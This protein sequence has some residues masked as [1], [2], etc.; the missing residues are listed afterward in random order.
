MRRALILALVLA[1]SA[2][3]AGL[4]PRSEDPRLI[5]WKTQASALRGLE[6]EHAVK[7]EW[8]SSGQIPDV[9]RG[10]LEGMLTPEDARRYRDAYAALGVVPPD[11][12]YVATM[13]RLQADSLAGLY[14]PRRKTLYV[15]DTLSDEDPNA[16]PGQSVIV[17]HELVHALQD[18]H[19]PELLDL[20][21]SL[22]RQD[23]VVGAVSSVLEGDAT[24]TMLGVGVQSGGPDARDARMAERVHH[25]MLAEAARTDGT[26]AGAPRLLRESMIFPYAWGTP[27]AARSFAA[28]G[29]AGLDGALRDPPLSTRQLL[30]PSDTAPVEF[31]RLPE[32]EIAT[33]VAVRGCTLGDD[34]V[35]GALTLRV[36]FED[37]APDVDGD[38]LVRGWRG[39]R[40][41]QIACAESPE[42]VWLTRWDSPA[43]AQR[44]A[45]AYREIAPGVAAHAPLAGRPEV[46]VRDRTALVVTPGL[47]DA[48]EWLI[49]AS[50]VRSY[51]T[52]VQ[53]RADGCFPETPCPIADAN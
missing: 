4:L 36:L 10:E 43:S 33:R 28:A 13:L 44:F 48:A 32:N 27:R 47:A 7:L 46:V 45:S 39:D 21:V 24:F 18:Q 34:N 31:V 3:C 37:Y 6:F 19:F 2:A 52:F 5:A 12:D 25:A 22:R 40:F 42:L 38:A 20:L 41:L 29:N 26:M 50:E 49:G 30:V 35:A 11:L 15:L 51:S 14:S 9:I 16:L 1:A 8:I 17:V 23:D 53:W